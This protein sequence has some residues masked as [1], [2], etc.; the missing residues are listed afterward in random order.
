MKINRLLVL[1]WTIEL[2]Q[3]RRYLFVL[4]VW[5]N[6]I[7]CTAVFA[8]PI[9]KPSPA[10]VVVVTLIST[11]IGIDTVG[12]RGRRLEGLPKLHFFVD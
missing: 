5:L 3:V 11:S 7:V 2:K 9:A 1:N 4:P 8:S 6:S 10:L 12:G